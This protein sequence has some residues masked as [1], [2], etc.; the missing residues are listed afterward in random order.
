[1]YEASRHYR[2]KALEQSEKR[3]RSLPDK[4]ALLT[5]HRAENTDDPTRIS[6]ILKALNRFN[7]IE[8][9]FPIHP[10]TRKILAQ[11]GLELKS[12]I[13]AIEPVGYFEML[14][15]EDKCSF[16][17]TDSG[18]VQKEAYFFQ[19]PCITLRDATE[20]REL[21]EHGWNTLVGA[22]ETAIFGALAS[23]PKYGDTVALYGDGTTAVRIAD[24]LLSWQKVR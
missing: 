21:V 4:F 1:M 18:G 17:V 6:A 3:L 10:R 13:H 16:V 14:A 11:Y 22:D 23:M 24:A 15:L 12:H 20:W 19:K 7:S 5:I 2:S 8:F 9:V